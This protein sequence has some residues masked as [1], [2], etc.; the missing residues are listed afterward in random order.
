M[1]GGSR[2]SYTSYGPI[3]VVGPWARFQPITFNFCSFLQSVDTHVG[4][5]LSKLIC[6]GQVITFLT[7]SQ[8]M[9]VL[10]H[11]AIIKFFSSR[12]FADSLSP[13]RVV[14]SLCIVSVLYLMH[15]VQFSMT[16]GLRSI[17]E[18]SKFYFSYQGHLFE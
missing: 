1:V 12:I 2:G 15:L 8:S 17:I 11:F 7:S 5:K 4:C 10:L 14:C 18:I 9:H 13:N 6:R 16:M 3:C